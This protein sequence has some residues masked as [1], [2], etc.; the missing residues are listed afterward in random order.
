M[1]DP[2][3]LK[4]IQ[5]EI[6]AGNVIASEWE[7]LTIYKYTQ[8]CHHENR[9]NDV[10]RQCRGLIL[11][12]HGRV[13]ARPFSKFFNLNEIEE[14][15]YDSLPWET[16]V[17]V[18]EK[19]D[20]SCGAMFRHPHYGIRLA[21][22]GSMESE[23]AKVG[24]NILRRS[25]WGK[26]FVADIPEDCTP[27]FEIIY[28]ENRI[29]VDYGK[30]EDLVLLAIFDFNG[31]EWHQNRVDATAEKYGISRPRRFDIDLKEAMEFQD[32]EEGY[33]C[34]FG[35][36]LRV[37]VK[38]PTYL[39]IHRLLNYLTPKGVIDLIRG[40]EYRTTLEQL[41]NSIQQSFDDIR[42]YV[43]T[44][45]DML[46]NK[47]EAFHASVPQGTRKDQALWITGCVPRELQGLVFAKLD[48]KDITEGLWRVVINSL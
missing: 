18:F 42:A 14:T 27:V 21:T 32:N 19:L 13:Y 22:P 30:R 11:D 25:H 26:H 8:D 47:V 1:R 4:K 3:L 15:K 48:N 41:P 39:R 24:T 29:V 36:G 9:W 2:I 38:S 12:K 5:K 16:G 34:R 44:E 23:Q 20:G 35:N 40:H 31:Q 33:V 10:N 28:P 17:E 37:K 7:G 45:F 43:Q 46:R 6:E